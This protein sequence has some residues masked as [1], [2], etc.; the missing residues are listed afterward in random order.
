MQV[1]IMIKKWVGKYCAQI[2]Q[3]SLWRTKCGE[4][5]NKIGSDFFGHSRRRKP[6]A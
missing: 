5:Y 3:R 2:W 1:N 6:V 4:W